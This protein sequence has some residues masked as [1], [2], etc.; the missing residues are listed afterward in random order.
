MQLKWVGAR[1]VGHSAACSDFIL[2]AYVRSMAWGTDTLQRGRRQRDGGHG[3]RVRIWDGTTACWAL[4]SLPG[5]P[6]SSSPQQQPWAWHMHM[7]KSLKPGHNLRP[8]MKGGH[9]TEAGWDLKRYTRK[10]ALSSLHVGPSAGGQH[11]T[12]GGTYMWRG[13]LT[14]GQW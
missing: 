11:G 10:K 7:E 13:A 4:S 2:T 8:K 1:T 12:V 9:T 6:T 3:P 5:W 14:L